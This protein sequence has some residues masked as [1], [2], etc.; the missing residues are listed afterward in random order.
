MVNKFWLHKW[1]I[2]D[3]NICGLCKYEV[4][5]V[6]HKYWSC[7]YVKQFWSDFNIYCKEKL[8]REI[9]KLDVLFGDDDELMCTLIFA[10]KRYI[11][12]SSIRDEVPKFGNFLNNVLYLKKVEENISIKNRKMDIWLR[13]WQPLC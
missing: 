7:T 10:A 13:K 8:N 6:I 11:N 5:D 1:N 3:D 9:K 2:A 4:D 12:S